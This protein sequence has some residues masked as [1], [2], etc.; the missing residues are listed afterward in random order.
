GGPGG[1]T[2]APGGG[3]EPIRSRP[4]ASRIPSTAVATDGNVQATWPAF[5]P[6]RKGVDGLGSKVS[7]WA[8]PPAIQRRI[9]VS[10]VGVI[11]PA[12]ASSA[13]SGRPPSEAIAASVAAPAALRNSRRFRSPSRLIAW[14]PNTSFRV[15]A[16]GGRESLL[17]S[18]PSVGERLDRS[19]TLPNPLREQILSRSVETRG[20]WPRS[21]AGPR[22]PPPSGASRGAPARPPAPPRSVAG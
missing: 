10:A 8:M 9:R 12:W 3:T 7:V 17:P 11:R 21:R 19:L 22:R 20:A 1:G 15:G 16:E 5:S 13:R 14:S 18:R 6:L 4:A 2:S